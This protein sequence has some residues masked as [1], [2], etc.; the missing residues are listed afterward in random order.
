MIVDKAKLMNILLKQKEYQVK[1]N[2]FSFGVF[3]YL[4]CK[5]KS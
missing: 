2:G 5:N 4:M 3:L 1:Q